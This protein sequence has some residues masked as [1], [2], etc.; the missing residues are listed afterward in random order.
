MQMS[1]YW[2]NMD[3]LLLCQGELHRLLVCF[4]AH[5]K[6]L[7]LTFTHI[8]WVYIKLKCHLHHFQTTFTLRT[9]KCL[10]FLDWKNSPR[11]VRYMK[12]GGPF[13]VVK[14]HPHPPPFLEPWGTFILKSDRKLWPTYFSWYFLNSDYSPYLCL[15]LLLLFFTEVNGMVSFLLC[16]CYLNPCLEMFLFLKQR[17]GTTCIVLTT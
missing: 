13:P 16:F 8:F 14:P 5:F 6:K 1:G 17:E 3:S 15:L 7:F 4:L 10:I 11:A 9:P 12:T 2:L